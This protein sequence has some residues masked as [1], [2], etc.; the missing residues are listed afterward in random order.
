MIATP[1]PRLRHLARRFLA[2]TRARFTRWTQPSPLALVAG[3]V[4]DAARSRSDV[5]LENAL[6]RHQLLV[7]GRTAGRPR[8]T[9]ADRAGDRPFLPEE[10]RHHH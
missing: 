1:L 2:A 3:A 8:L 4:A 6:L 7:L 5:L 10:W 9:A